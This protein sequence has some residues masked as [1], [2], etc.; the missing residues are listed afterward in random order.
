MSAIGGSG[1]AAIAAAALSL[2][3][4]PFRLHGRNPHYGLDCVGL[5]EQ[6]LRRAGQSVQ[7]P[8]QYGLRMGSIEHL[9]TFAE[10]AHLHAV[11]DRLACPQSRPGDILLVRPGPAQFHLLVSLTDRGFVHAHAGLRRVVHSPTPPEWRS[12]RHWRHASAL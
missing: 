6:S 3:G 8:I 12:E 10:R 2:V 9:L 5:V 11:G 7:A 1:G 4:S